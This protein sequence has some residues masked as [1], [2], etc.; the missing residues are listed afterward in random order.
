MPSAEKLKR[1]IVLDAINHEDIG[2]IPY[3]LQFEP[4]IGRKMARYYG[5]ESIDEYVDNGIELI[6]IPP[7]SRVPVIDKPSLK[8]YSFPQHLSL[9]QLAHIKA[10]SGKSINKY[11]IA[12]LGALWI[13]AASLR[14]MANLMDDL[15]DHPNFVHELLDGILDVFLQYVEI[16]SNEMDFECIILSDG[17]GQGKNISLPVGTWQEYML[18]RLQRLSDAVHAADFHFALS[19]SDTVDLNIGDIVT[20]GVDIL[21]P[22]HSECID[23]LG[24]NREYGQYITLWGVYGTHGTLLFST[25]EHVRD[26]IN[27]LCDLLGNGGGFIFSPAGKIHND[28]PIENAAALIEV[29]FERERGRF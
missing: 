20:M 19:T 6:N 29:A 25:P 5:V 11:R 23:I 1:N 10:Q 9:E 13:Q 24:V 2:C 3:W 18:P 28:V 16:C 26:E 17:F 15:V 22:E 12:D 27:E 7:L 14:G 4:A 8:G 21:K